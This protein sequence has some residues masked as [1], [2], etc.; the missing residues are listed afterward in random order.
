MGVTAE[1]DDMGKASE[2]TNDLDKPATA[3]IVLLTRVISG[4]VPGTKTGINAEGKTAVVSCRSGPDKA[5]DID[6][7]VDSITTEEVN[8]SAD[9]AENGG[10][11]LTTIL[12]LFGRTK[13]REY[14][15][16]E[17]T[18]YSLIRKLL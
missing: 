15:H 2:V 12:R 9:R 17:S 11:S 1:K 6:P 7:V 4:E 16:F 3:N 18:L 5:P 13:H 10:A 14:H 8:E